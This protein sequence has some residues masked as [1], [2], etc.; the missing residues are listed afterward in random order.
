MQVAGS[1]PLPVITEAHWLKDLLVA[2]NPD[3]K[4][5][6]VLNGIEKS[7]FNK[8]KENGRPLDR[9]DV[10]VEGSLDAL[11][12]NTQMAL[13][14]SLSSQLASSVLHVGNRPYLTDDPRYQFVESTLS[15]D[16]MAELYARHHVLVKTPIAEGMFGPPLEA[17][18]CGLPALVTP[19]TGAEEYIEDG[20]NAFLVSW[21]N[22]GE[23]AQRI[24]ELARNRSL[25][26]QLSA[27]ALATADA[28]PDW[29]QQSSLFEEMLKAVSKESKL[30]QHD[31]ANMG[32][33]I[34]FADLM[35][36]LAMRR[37]S[38]KDAGPKITESLLA[39]SPPSF[40]IRLIRLLHRV[41][42]AVGFSR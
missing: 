29:D 18:H 13:Q 8:G 30:S 4:V 2:E 34:Q 31:L 11:A 23:I 16:E 25:W 14:G 42:N 9:F 7:I 27:G 12:K 39:P 1:I 22:P 20:V 26:N 40:S 19:V 28:W 5:E 24:D 41:S 36:W 21:N 37:L 3:R 35:H 10:L 32:R 38:D 15:F 17:F 6:V 33:T